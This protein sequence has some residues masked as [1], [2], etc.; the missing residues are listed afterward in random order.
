VESKDDE[1]SFDLSEHSFCFFFV[2]INNKYRRKY[3]RVL[4]KSIAAAMNRQITA[5]TTN[6]MLKPFQFCFLLVPPTNSYR[7]ER[8]KKKIIIEEDFLLNFLR[9]FILKSSPYKTNN[10]DNYS[11]HPLLSLA[12]V[13]GAVARRTSKFFSYC[14]KINNSQ[15]K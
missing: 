9:S 3:L 7:Q 5:I 8:K 1:M 11:Y 12:V 13:V 2:L 10:I 4:V 6:A 15:K 14:K